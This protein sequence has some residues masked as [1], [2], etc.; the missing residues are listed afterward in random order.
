M[1]KIITVDSDSER[2][3]IAALIYI[4]YFLFFFWGGG[5]LKRNN[6]VRI[7]MFSVG[8]MEKCHFVGRNNGISRFFQRNN[9]FFF[10]GIMK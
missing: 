10:T 1:K 8:I 4:F 7:T 3:N 9:E 5:G 6:G 2:L